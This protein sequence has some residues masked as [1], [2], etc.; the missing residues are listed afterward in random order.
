M[1]SAHRRTGEERARQGDPLVVGGMDG[2]DELVDMVGI[3]QG[4]GAT[5]ETCAG[6]S[7]AE[8]GWVAPRQIGHQVEL[9]AGNSVEIAQAGMGG[10]HQLTG[11]HQVAIP[12]ALVNHGHF[13]V[14]GVKVTKPSYLL[15]PGDIIEIRGREN[16]KN[17]YR[18]V[19]ANATPDA[20]DWVS[21]DSENLKATVLGMPGSSDISLPVDANSV[22]EFLSR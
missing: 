12:Q 18:G 22:V 11:L 5:T 9:F 2:A 7:G 13:R 16:L 17:L 1:G 8:A 6:E 20:I 4:H 15:R 10:V 19:I 3:D 14:N 21:L